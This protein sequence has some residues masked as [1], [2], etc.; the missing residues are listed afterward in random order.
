MNYGAVYHRAGGQYCYPKNQDEL[1]INLKTGYEV[2]Q[3]WLVSGD[4]YEAGIA[5]GAERWNGT[6][7][8]I[9]F[10]KDLKFQRWWTTT[11]R[12][13]YK[14]LK[15]YFILKA[16]GEYYYYFENGFLTEEQMEKEG[17]MLQYFICPWMNESDISMTP[18]WVQRTV[19]YQIFPERFCNGNPDRNRPG[20]KP[21]ET[22]PVTNEEFFG[23]D[24]EGI[25]MKLDYLQMVGITGIYLTPI[26][27]SPSSHKYDTRDY[28]QIDAAFGNQKVFHK[29]ISEAHRRGIRIMIDMVFNHCGALFSKWQDVVQYGPNSGFY[30]WFMVNKWP[31]EPESGNTRDRRYYSFAFHEDMPK[32]NT[33]NPEVVDYLT[34]I[35]IYWVKEYGVDGLRFD[36]GN[37]VSHSFIRSLRTRIKTLK[38]DLYLLGEIWHD[39]GEWLDGTQYDGVMNYPLAESINDFWVDRQLTN[40][41]FAHMVNRSYTMYREAHNQALF[42]LL[43]SHDTDRLFTRVG[44]N[45]DAFYQ[46][47]TVLFTMPGSPCIFY[48]TEVALPGGHDPDCRRCMPWDDI[49]KGVYHDRMDMIRKLIRLRRENSCFISP[50]FHFPELGT[51]PRVIVYEK[52]SGFG[53]KNIVVLN[54]SDES[55]KIVSAEVLF[56]WKYEEDILEPGGIL[57]TGDYV[58]EYQ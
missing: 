56:S 45:E 12:P 29:L 27:D 23:G 47:L 18:D 38:P 31:L 19:W 15:Y 16:G 43:D 48:G 28:Y 58:K 52:L 8:E 36:V 33:N 4:P 11:V 2:E 40:R 57:V 32:L 54:C 10:K 35:C 41:D 1:I 17:R 20:T 5:G 14:R 51:N 55:V 7:E 50:Y 39:A 46:Q 9:F 37:E 24:L 49:K 13:P 44:E 53:E 21:W 25:L 22:R 30:D 6:K 3:V 26:F 34:N 42:N